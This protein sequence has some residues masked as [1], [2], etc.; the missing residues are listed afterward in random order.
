MLHMQN[1]YFSASGANG[2]F[3]WSGEISGQPGGQ[4]KPQQGGNQITNIQVN[5]NQQNLHSGS[6]SGGQNPG[7]DCT[8]P[9]GQNPGQGETPSGGQMPG[10]GGMPSGG[11][12]PGQGG[13]PSGGQMPGQSE[14]PSGGQ[15]P[16]QGG[17]PS[18]GQIIGQPG[19]QPLP[20]P[21]SQGI[22]PTLRPQAGAASVLDLRHHM[23]E[24]QIQSPVSVDE[25]HMGSMKSIL[26]RNLGNFVVATFLVGTQG[27]TSWEG[28]LY[29]V[30]NDYLV[31]YQVGRDRYIVCDIYSLKYIEFYDTSRQAQCENLMLNQ[32]WQ[33][34][35]WQ[36]NG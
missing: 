33:N 21:Q 3:D 27:T 7:Q 35:G 24:E 16:G 23:T 15:M 6:A 9:G 36:Q 8:L 4:E 29:E 11:Q 22:I 13:T 19:V 18:G 31:I 28:M 34:N 14:M 1:P 30:G 10:Q 25:A 5:Q 32:G 2:G 12:M 17:T 26:G 20:F